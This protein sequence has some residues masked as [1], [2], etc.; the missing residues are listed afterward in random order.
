MRRLAFMMQQL[1]LPLVHKLC[2]IFMLIWFRVPKRLNEV[3]MQ[4]FEIIFARF[5]NSSQLNCAPMI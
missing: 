1:R 4:F 5:E 2:L 3:I